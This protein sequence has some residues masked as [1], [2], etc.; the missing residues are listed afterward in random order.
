MYEGRFEL[1]RGFYEELAQR[2][3]RERQRSNAMRRECRERSSAKYGLLANLLGQ[4]PLASTTIPPSDQLEDLIETA[5][6]ASLQKEEGRSLAFTLS[7]K[8]SSTIRTSIMGRSIGFDEK[9]DV[10][11]IGKLAPAVPRDA[12]IVVAPA[13]NGKLSIC[14]LD[15][16][17]AAPFQLK[18]IDPGRVVVTYLGTRVALT[19][20]EG[21][22]NIS[23]P[24]GEQP[25]LWSALPSISDTSDVAAFLASHDFVYN[26]VRA[27]R[28]LGHGGIVVIVPD[29]GAWNYPGYRGNARLTFIGENIKSLKENANDQERY[30][31]NDSLE[32]AARDVA[33]LTAVD[34]AVL[35]T[36]DL[37][38]VGFGIKLEPRCKSSDIPRMRSVDPTEHGG[39]PSWTTLREL[40]VGMRHHSAARSVFEEKSGIAFVVSEDGG[41]TAFEWKDDENDPSESSL[42]AYKRLELTLL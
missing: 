8:D 22:A 34:G 5:F 10:R 4:S 13:S 14:G 12:A 42:W 30:V 35:L 15:L 26:T 3:E 16:M 11:A 20:A 2:L 7:Y 27:V 24:L 21:A 39:Q 23:D 31:L 38:V 41:V 40:R 9:F 6:W 19:S 29:N 25:S 18:I 28:Y 17:D 32:R 1:N 37:D 36:R 33:Q